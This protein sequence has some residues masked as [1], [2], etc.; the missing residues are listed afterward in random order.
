[1]TRDSNTQCFSAIRFNLQHDRP[2]SRT[3]REIP[4]FYFVRFDPISQSLYFRLIRN[5]LYEF[6]FMVALN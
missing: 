4:C 2:D 5:I 1:M 6:D 3:L